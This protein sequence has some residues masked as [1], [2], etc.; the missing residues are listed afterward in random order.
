MLVS[1]ESCRPLFLAWACLCVAWTS[2]AFVRADAL[3]G[4]LYVQAT[5][6]VE[7]LRNKGYKNVGVLNFRT[8]LPGQAESMVTGALNVNLAE[9]LEN[10]LILRVDADDGIRVIHDA[11]SVIAAQKKH[12]SY[13]RPQDL[14]EMFKL[15]YPVAWGTERVKP[16]VFLS[17]LAKL[18]VDP[19]TRKRSMEVKV[20]ALRPGST[21][22]ILTFSPKTEGSVLSDLG[23]SRRARSPEAIA[24]FDDVE[25]K[26]KPI[27]LAVEE[28]NP[29][30]NPGGSKVELI[31]KY[32]N[33]EH[34]PVPDPQNSTREKVPEP[35][36]AGERI[37][38]LV[39]NLDPTET[40]AIVLKVNGL[41]TLDLEQKAIDNCRLWVL[42]PGTQYQISGYHVGEQGGPDFKVNE[43][44]TVSGKDW[45]SLQTKFP[46]VGQIQLAVYV[47]QKEPDPTPLQ[48][49]YK[50]SL[51]GI[52]NSK[53]FVDRRSL[54]LAQLKLKISRE[55]GLSRLAKPKPA[56]SSGI[57]FEDVPINRRLEL[58]DFPNPRRIEDRMIFYVTPP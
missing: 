36:V 28:I 5:Q 13:L 38:F 11:G 37:T 52:S 12:W 20:Q 30:Q 27:K 45:E 25:L 1:R 50:V 46:A 7:F 51:R 19:I 31:V 41:N 33:Q 34:R 26:K 6:V 48:Y 44:K 35:T 22:T 55:S 3:D 29:S 42:K 17:G 4:E 53:A 9:R 15:T 24:D 8:Q 32:G 18:T 16:D 57:G 14:N 40:V 21:A 58:K 47:S 2:P 23:V 43:F 10:A 49:Q 56:G 39:K 54:D